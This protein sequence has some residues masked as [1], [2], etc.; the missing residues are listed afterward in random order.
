MKCGVAKYLLLLFLVVLTGCEKKIPRDIIQPSEMK[1]LL[2][3]YHLANV[4]SNEV[5]GNKDY[6][7][8]LYALYMFDKHGVTK[9]KFDS[10]MVWYTRNPKHLYDIYSSLYNRLDAEVALLSGEKVVKKSDKNKMLKDTVNLWIDEKVLLFSSAQ[11]MQKRVFAYESD[12]TYALGDSISFAMN[13]HFIK[14]ME[15][16]VA[17]R[18]QAALVVE[19]ADSTYSSGGVSIVRDGRY[20]IEL[21]RNSESLVKRINGYIYY[22]DD[23]ELQRARMLVG[24]ISLMRI[25]PQI[26][27][28]DIQ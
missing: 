27:N 4:M 14:P 22:A 20:A 12:S 10:S 17:P 25:H 26:N 23:D 7:Q 28:D 2:Y 3:D 1:E 13:V 5:G 15:A 18:A 9:E 24:D 19:Y 21:P 16:D 8:K 6:E 11:Y